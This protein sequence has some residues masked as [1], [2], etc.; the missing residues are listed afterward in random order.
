RFAS[1]CRAD[2]A[3]VVGEVGEDLDLPACGAGAGIAAQLF[4]AEPAYG[5]SE[6]DRSWV[7]VVPALA[8]SIEFAWR[9]GGA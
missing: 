1:T 5:C 3:F 4:V 7:A 6:Q 2:S 8:T 9:A